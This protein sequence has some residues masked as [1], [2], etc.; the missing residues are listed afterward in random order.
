MSKLNSRV[1]LGW[2]VFIFILALASAYVFHSYEL[3]VSGLLII[4]I[5]T[6]FIP[7]WRITLLAG[8]LGMVVMT[9]LLL[10]F[11]EEGSDI[12]KAMLSQV[13]SLLVIIFAVVIVF[14]LKR[15]QQNFAHE[16]TH[17]I[18][19]FE[20]ATEGILLTNHTGQI[21]LANPAAAK[22]FGS[23]HND[24]IENRDGKTRTNHAGGVVGG[25]PGGPGASGIAC[26]GWRHQHRA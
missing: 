19:L 16:K 22:M 10:Y 7:G 8:L 23:Q 5:L 9:G 24:A 26:R 20:N 17:M 21:V 2:S 25:G 3:A 1:I 6:A 14:Y 15:L 11:K 18:S 4:I 12:M 13:Y